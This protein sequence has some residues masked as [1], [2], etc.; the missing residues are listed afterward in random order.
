MQ[1]A[2]VSITQLLADGHSFYVPFYQRAYVWPENLWNRF[3]RDMEY[4]SKT[5]EEY[6]IGSVIL[7]KLGANGIETARW[8]V[9]DGQQ[10][11]TT[12]SLIMIA[13]ARTYMQMGEEGTKIANAMIQVLNPT[14]NTGSGTVGKLP[15]IISQDAKNTISELVEQNVSI[16][17][18]AW[19]SYETSWDFKR[20]P[21]V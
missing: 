18:S 3:I 15:I 19:D 17:R 4:I 21:R 8:A 10:R 1:P 16:A 2:K 6:F 12:L 11:L 20:N 7:K 13:I 14:I 5:D 9:V